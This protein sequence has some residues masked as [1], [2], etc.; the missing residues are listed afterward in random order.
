M[1]SH[2]LFIVAWESAKH[3]KAAWTVKTHSLMKCWAPKAA[4]ACRV[5][6]QE[7][8]FCTLYKSVASLFNMYWALIKESAL[9]A[10]KIIIIIRK[11]NFNK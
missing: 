7:S 1:S 10:Q 11:H 6:G 5:R 4:A 9:Q 8:V 3:E 2:G